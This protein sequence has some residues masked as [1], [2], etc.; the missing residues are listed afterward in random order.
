MKVELRMPKKEL[1]VLKDFI[2]LPKEQQDYFINKLKIMSPESPLKV[3]KE[4]EE[5]TDFKQEI[6]RSF[7]EFAG[8]F[9]LNYY[10]FKRFNL[11]HDEF[12]NDV[13]IDS[14]KGY[15]MELEIEDHTKEIL[16][17]ILNMEDSIGMLSKISS[18]SKESPNNFAM[19][20]IITDLRHIYYNNPSK[21]PCYS[22]IKHNLVI[23][24]IDNYSKIKEKFF[25]L[26]L[27]DLLELRKVVERAIEKEKTLKIL[28]KKKD[29][30]IIKEV[31][32]FE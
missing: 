15:D 24:Y 23:N 5:N 25:S 13:V 27:D 21:I 3:I 2:L 31:D 26:D 11:T 30:I 6:I 19:V 18:L 29:I 7:L 10:S 14:I 12:I 1:E 9:Y 28:C 17:E 22:L 4:I 8:S 16:K 20:R 32:W